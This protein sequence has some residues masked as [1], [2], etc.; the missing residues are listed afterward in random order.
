MEVKACRN[1]KRLFNYLSGP[2]ICMAC[3][4]ELEKKF[5]KVKEYIRENKTVSVKEISEANEVSVKQIQQWIREER[6]EFTEDSPITLNC[7]TCGKK[8]FTGR[9]CQDC[10]KNLASGLSNTVKKTEPEPQQSEKKKP[11]GNHM[12][13]LH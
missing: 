10:K 7:E 12:R 11:G 4:D 6:L 13:F 5:Q 3:K 2:P 9:L 1:C 8:I